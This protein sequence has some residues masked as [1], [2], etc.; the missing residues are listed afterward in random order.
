VLAL[1]AIFR[2]LYFLEGR[3]KKEEGRRKKEEGR[4]R[5]INAQ[6]PMPHAQFRF[7]VVIQLK[8]NRKFKELLR[9]N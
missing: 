6:C 9:N 8:S 5:L 7:I 1:P 2:P 4:R 3:R